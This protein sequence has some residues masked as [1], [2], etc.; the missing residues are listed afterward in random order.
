MENKIVYKYEHKDEIQR[1]LFEKLINKIYS[2]SYPKPNID[3]RTMNKVYPLLEKSVEK[4]K[5]HYPCDF[6]YI[7]YNVY[8]ILVDDF[9][10]KYGIEFHWKTNMDFLLKILFGEG[11][12]KEVYSADEHNDKPY[13]H[14]VD[15]EVLEKYI[16]KEYSDKVKE[17]IEGYANTYRFGSRDYNDI[18]FSTSMYAPSCNKENVMKAWKEVFGKD[19]IIPEDNTWIDEYEEADEEWNEFE[20][21]TDNEVK[22]DEDSLS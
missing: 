22:E 12:I 4:T 15:V 3:F 13:R 2:L 6:Y 10:D 16:P 5:Y 14:C 19:I 20:D 9:L 17:I 1:E 11:G 18:L 7:P 8:K 21:I